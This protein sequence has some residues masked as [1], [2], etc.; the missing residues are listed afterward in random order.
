MKEA[1]FTKKQGKGAPNPFFQVLN[2]APA[3]KGAA[4]FLRKRGR[5]PF[6]LIL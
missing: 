2:A 6:S 3:E 1:V 5:C 4:G